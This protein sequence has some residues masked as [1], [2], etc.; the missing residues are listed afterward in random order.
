MG[1]LFIANIAPL[2]AVKD[3]G[4][5][6]GEAFPLADLVGSK[7][8]GGIEAAA[9]RFVSETEP[10]V[11]ARA[12][13]DFDAVQRLSEKG[14][15]AETTIADSQNGA[16]TQTGRVGGLAE[17][18]QQSLG[19]ARKVVHFDQLL[20]GLNFAGRS[21]FAGLFDGWHFDKTNGQ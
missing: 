6:P 10:A 8:L 20:I 13:N 14:T 3:A 9:T 1:H 16:R 19:A 11:A 7:D 21:A 5:L 17:L 4:V 2:T 15:V 12:R 18:L